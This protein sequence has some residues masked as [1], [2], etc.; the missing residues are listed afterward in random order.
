MP[1]RRYILSK[2]IVEKKLLR[3]AYEIVERNPGEESLV[4]VGIRDSGYIIASRLQAI[5]ASL[6]KGK[7]ELIDIKIDK[8]NP[9]AVILS[10]ELPLNDKVVILIDDVANTGR[11]ILYSLKPFLNYYPKKIQTLVLVERTH[12]RFPIKSD[13][14]GL[15]ISTTLLEHIM[16]EIHDG[17]IE[18]AYL[19]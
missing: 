4:L 19:Q 16:V 1:E 15:S 10:S 7:V 17:V 11:T 6:F 18:G 14:V 8:K 12:K 3:I 2:E 13:Y 5:L 9:H